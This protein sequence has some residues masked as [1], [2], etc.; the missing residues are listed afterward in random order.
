[1]SSAKA[2]L[3]STFDPYAQN[4]QKSQRYRAYLS[5]EAVVS[6]PEHRNLASL[7]PDVFESELA[8]FHRA[9]L[10]FGSSAGAMASRFTSATGQTQTDVPEVHVAFEAQIEAAHAGRFGHRTRVIESW[11]PTRLLCKRFGVPDPH[12]EGKASAAVDTYESRAEIQ[13][14]R[15]MQIEQ[16]MQG[17]APASAQVE[18]SP[19]IL[20]SS[21]M[22][23]S[24][25]GQ[26]TSKAFQELFKD[27]SDD[28]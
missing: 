23:K 15:R 4:P 21:T 18:A 20:K 9:A 8:E 14:E 24:G 7:A 1:M 2:A 10:M 5:Q 27:D 22:K 12:P 19:E 25:E 28:D 6:V 11:F 16:L 3:T 17:P 26:Q 13:L